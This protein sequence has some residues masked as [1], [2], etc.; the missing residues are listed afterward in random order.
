M[1][2]KNKVA[3]VTGAASLRGIAH[4]F[5]LIAPTLALCMCTRATSTLRRWNRAGTCGDARGERS[6]SERASFELLV[7]PGLGVCCRIDASFAKA[8]RLPQ[9]AGPRCKRGVEIT[10][11]DAQQC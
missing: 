7:T 3:I 6:S 9:V 8:C 11:V 4:D 5:R 10:T 2:L 1:L